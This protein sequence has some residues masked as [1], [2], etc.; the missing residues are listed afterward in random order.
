MLGTV[1]W[2]RDPWLSSYYPDDLPADW[3]LSYYANECGCVV[4]SPAQGLSDDFIE[5]FADTHDAFRCFILVAPDQC[6]GDIGALEDLDPE[7]S[8]VLLDHAQPGFDRM[9]QWTA[10]PG[11][12]W[13]AADGEGLLT[14]WTIDEFTLRDLRN[15]VRT[16]AADASAIVLDGAGADPGRITELRTLVDLMGRGAL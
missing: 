14:R 10:G 2:Q 11:E 12:S 9:P 7:R 8:A 3:R 15:R 16:L 4:V 1:H 13:R 5:Q 6:P